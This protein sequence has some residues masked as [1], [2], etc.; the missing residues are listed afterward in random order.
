MA[1]LPRPI[2]IV[3]ITLSCLGVL[4]LP[5]GIW[6]LRDARHR[7]LMEGAALF[8]S[9]VLCFYFAFRRDSWLMTALEG[10]GD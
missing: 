4:F 9:A 6:F 7:Y 1:K 10:L 5:L 3:R 8:V 2:H